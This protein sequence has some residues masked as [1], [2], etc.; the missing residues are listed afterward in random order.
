M[1]H[2]EHNH[3]D[4][5]LSRRDALKG[6]LAATGVTGLSTLPG[7]WEAPLIEVGLLPPLAQ[8]S[9][10]VTYPFTNDI[11]MRLIDEN[12]N[13][14]SNATW[15][16]D[17]GWGGVYINP[18]VTTQNNVT[19]QNG[20]DLFSRRPWRRLRRRRV[21]APAWAATLRVEVRVTF[22]PIDDDDED[23]IPRGR[24]FCYGYGLFG[25]VVYS[26]LIEGEIDDGEVILLFPI[27]I[28]FIGFFFFS[29]FFPT[30]IVLE[31][32]TELDSSFYFGPCLYGDDSPYGEDDT[33][34]DLDEE[35]E[36]NE[37]VTL[38]DFTLIFTGVTYDGDLSTWSY[39][40]GTTGV[41]LSRWVLALPL[42]GECATLDSSTPTGSEVTPDETFGIIGIQ[43][44][45]TSGDF[46]VT[47]SGTVAVGLVEVGV[48]GND[49]STAAGQIVGPVCQ[50]AADEVTLENCYQI[51]FLGAENNG[52]G[53]SSWTYLMTE[54]P[55]AQDLSNWV[56][57]LPLACVSVVGETPNGE[58]VTPDPNANLDGIKWQTG[59]GFV[60]GQFTV[61]LSGELGVDL[62]IGVVDVAAKGPDVAFGQIS[63]PVCLV[64]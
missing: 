37:E 58:V 1:R 4:N 22:R 45:A 61:I 12:G 5:L 7:R 29:C 41:E 39:T 57:A 21:P 20:D 6:M 64:E 46:A 63:G 47:L 27:P 30:I 28:G 42:L 24:L 17:Q 38:G 59:A 34:D 54:L 19:G 52:D 55:C 2:S 10:V 18:N 14:V 25:G 49:D 40:I 15:F 31:D 36:G 62:A 32:E 51:A 33:D 56:L 23:R 53:T 48:V 35:I 16:E 13:E 3:Q 26:G 11:T 8:I 60:Q 44:D 43:W 9:G 50:E